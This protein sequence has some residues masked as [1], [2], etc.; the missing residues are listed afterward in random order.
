MKKI[1]MALA[2]SLIAMSANATDVNNVKD[3]FAEGEAHG[4]IKYYFIE[5]NKEDD[6]TA[7]DSSAWANSIGGKLGFTTAKLYGFTMGGTFMTTNPFALPDNVDTSIIGRDNAVQQGLPAGDPVAQEGFSVLGEM[8]LDYQY[9]GLDA[10]YGRRIE[11]TPLVNPKEVRMIPSSIEGGDVSY[12][13]ENGI[14]IGGGYLDKFKQRTSS[15]F[16]NIVEHALGDQT[17]TITGHNV[18][19]VLPAYLEWR[20][21]DH[22][23]RLYN[24]YSQDYMNMTYFDAIHKHQVNDEFS[25][26]AALQGMHQHGIGNSVGAMEAN[27]ADYGGKI[28]GR[29]FGLKAGATYSESSFL[30][31]YTNVLGSR[32]NEHNSLTLPWDGTP[33]FS[34]MITSN[35][36]FT[37]NYGKGL[38]SSAGYIAGTSGIKAGYTQKYNFTGVNGFKSVLSYAYYDNTNFVKAQQDINL[39]LAYGIGNF[40]LALKGIWVSNN[41]GNTASDTD[42]KANEV[43]S[44]ITQI[45]KLT[46]YRVIANYTF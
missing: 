19:N 3:W 37:S 39:V 12:S 28:N 31:A 15:R 41:T 20:D 16:V 22:T 18:G 13:F 46:Q 36:L 29:F 38:T 17:E 45:D 42:S 33:L 4:N 27:T 8:Y 34:D 21:Q 5:T 44:S 1:T 7:T 43:G 26:M 35:D 32:E 25:W 23:V 14:K 10:W 30:F 9:Q 2:S 11:K 6:A 24:Y 40:S